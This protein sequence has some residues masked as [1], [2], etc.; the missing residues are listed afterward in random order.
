M[1]IPYIQKTVTDPLTNLSSS[2]TIRFAHVYSS[3]CIIT[4]ESVK[5]DDSG[6]H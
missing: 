3:H 6:A 4:K 1:P 5:A 2:E